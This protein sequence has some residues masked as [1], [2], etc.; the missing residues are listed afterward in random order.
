MNSRLTTPQTQHKNLEH[1][2]LRFLTSLTASVEKIVNLYGLNK[3][4]NQEI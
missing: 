1:T 4:M 3:F 2:S